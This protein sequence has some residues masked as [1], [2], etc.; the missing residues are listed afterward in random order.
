MSSRHKVPQ[1]SRENTDATIVKSKDTLH[2]LQRQVTSVERWRGSNRPKDLVENRSGRFYVLNKSEAEFQRYLLPLDDSLLAGTVE[3]SGDDFLDQKD[4]EK[5]DEDSYLRL[6][7]SSDDD[8]DDFQSSLDERFIDSSGGGD[9]DEEENIDFE[10]GNVGHGDIPAPVLAIRTPWRRRSPAAFLETRTTSATRPNTTGAQSA[11]GAGSTPLVSKAV[12][13]A[14]GGR[15]CEASMPL[16]MMVTNGSNKDGA[17]D[18]NNYRD[19]ADYN[20][21][22]Q[23]CSDDI[24]EDQPSETPWLHELRMTITERLHELT[25]RLYNTIVRTVMEDQPSESRGCMSGR[26]PPSAELELTEGGSIDA[27]RYLFGL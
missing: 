3:D 25:E 4:D 22:A 21:A 9:A 1:S 23:Q 7:E 18:R 15:C 5:D 20:S 11:N 2:G 17:V 14:V 12:P 26:S 19:G 16:A 10:F 27:G 6:E 24:F 8:T 13:V